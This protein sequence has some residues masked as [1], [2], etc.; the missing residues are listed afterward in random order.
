[1]NILKNILIRLFYIFL[2]SISKKKNLI[3]ETKQIF[4][5]FSREYFHLGD[6]LFFWPTILWLESQ[7]FE[8]KISSSKLELKKFPRISHIEDGVFLIRPDCYVPG[9]VSF[10][11]W[12]GDDRIAKDIFFNSCRLLGIDVSDYNYND[13]CRLL[14]KTLTGIKTESI[15]E[16]E[17]INNHFNIISSEIDSGMWRYFGNFKNILVSLCKNIDAHS[18]NIHIGK[19]P[20]NIDLSVDIHKDLGGITDIHDLIYLLSSKNITNVYTF[21]TIVYHIAFLLNKK[22]ICQP[23]KWIYQR[24]SQQIQK[25][26]IPAF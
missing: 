20:I 2:F 8:I 10:N 4:F 22:I 7:N 9:S 19:K 14:T 23:R 26:F 18:I 15:R 24:K 12:D 17:F 25:R 3:P 21:D 1:M 11:V 13:A 5:N 16:F 6:E